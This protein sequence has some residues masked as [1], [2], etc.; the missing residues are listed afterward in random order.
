M[1]ASGR[2]GVWGC[3][4][5]LGFSSLYGRA[6]GQENSRGE[7]GTATPTPLWSPLEEGTGGE[8]VSVG[9]SP[10]LLDPHLSFQRVV[11]GADGVI[12]GAAADEGGVAGEGE[13]LIYSNTLGIHAINFPTN[14][15]VSD[16]IATTA[17]NG[18]ALTRYRFKVLGKVLPSGAS[19][20]YTVTYGLYTNCP[21]A[22]GS[23]SATRDLVR[24]P[25]T[26]GVLS[27]PDD[28]PRL[29]EHV[30]P[31]GTPVA[32]P[33]NV[34]LGI[35]FNRGNCGTVVGAPASIGY[36]GDIWDFPG[37]PCNGWL[38]GFP[39]MPHASFWLEMFGSDTCADSFVGYKAQRPSG[40]TATLGANIQGVDDVQLFVDDC[41][42]V[43]YEVVVRGVGFYTFDLRREC[44]G[45]GIAGTE[46]TFQVNVGTTP[47]LQVARFPIQPPIPLM[48]DSLY[49]R[50]K[51][52][53]NSAGAVITGIPPIIG[54]SDVNY[55]TTGVD[56]CDP[57]IATQG[58]HGAVNLAITCAG[59]LPPGACCDPYL[60]ECT[61]GVDTGKR[62]LSN[63]D[64]SAP[65]TCES[66][67]RQ[68]TEANCPF[69]PPDSDLRPQWQ[70]GEAC[71]PNPFF[72][73]VCGVAACCHKKPNPSNP[74]IL[75][76]VCENLTNNECNSAPPLDQPREWQI[77]AYCAVGAQHCPT[78]PC[79]GR[80]GCVCVTS[81]CPCD[82]CYPDF[83]PDQG[84]CDKVCA[85]ADSFCCE[86][87][88][89]S[90]C[91][92]LAF[93]LCGPDVNCPVGK[94]EFI[95]PPDG[96]VDARRQY[97][98]GNPAMS[99]SI[100]TFVATGPSDA[101]ERCW[102]FC[103]SPDVPASIFITDVV[104]SPPGTYTIHLSRPIPPVVNMIT[105]TDDDGQKAVGRFIAHPANVNADSESNSKDILSLI[106]YLNGIAPLPW[107][108]YSG[109]LDHSGVIGP[110]DIVTLIDLLNGNGFA[111]WYGTALPNA[112]RCP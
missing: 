81:P 87:S 21:L 37:F 76:E 60:T 35:R 10:A 36:S 25:G 105:Y 100:R 106:D 23:N 14:Q 47:L 77:G 63:T 75:D 48:T 28:G 96:V 18:C 61:G 46:R 27:F 5:L 13:R 33:S 73:E 102:S 59:R 9:V 99:D 6:A 53:S 20:A 92:D 51:C 62:C 34:Y 111:A 17:L 67:C 97:L 45:Q 72:P 112:E 95:E 44:D 4:F 42:M 15:P 71:D 56:G 79:L 84:C 50:F 7:E 43:G 32:L 98:P 2:I 108:K 93:E 55:F 74:N 38:G 94:I 91:C 29:I 78:N 3:A 109:D 57:V 31:A 54:S 85:T 70:Q 49:V 88:W 69:P 41:Q 90:Y 66:V 86:V 52:S 11:V 89:N 8:R 107:G 110:A 64:C 58:V 40:G 82:P 26:E 83:P 24:I 80:N 12:R 39:D 16:D 101:A 19:G 22:V 30:V 1:V 68:T 104:E 103:E 65:G